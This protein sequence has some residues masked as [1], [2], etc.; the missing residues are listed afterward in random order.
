MENKL[1][2]NI[3]AFRK[4]RM[5]TQE[6]LAEVLGVTVGAVYKWE[7]RLSQPELGTIM[8][9][10]DFFDT[11]VDVLLG[12]EMKD[13]RLQTTTERLKKYRSDKDAAGLAD[14]EKALKK[15]PNS[16][17]I[18]YYSAALYGAFGMERGEKRLLRRALELFEKSRHLIS[19]NA[20]PR[21]SESTLCGSIAEVLLNL[22]ETKRAVDMLK[23]NNADGMYSDRIGLT[24]ADAF[25]CPE[26]ALT[27]LSES[28]VENTVKIIRT[29]FGYVTV[30][31]Q[32]ADFDSAADVL[33]FGIML[34][35][36]L[37]R[38]EK[39]NYMDRP[40]CVLFACL[41]YS[42]L[43]KGD[44]AG[45]ERVL[46]RAKAIAERFDA[47]PNYGV[48]AVRFVSGGEQASAYDDI[49][50]TAADGVRNTVY[51]LD[52]V[53]LIKIWERVNNDEEQSN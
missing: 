5:L 4:Q 42:R 15:Y 28:L 1:A 36:G 27:Y 10:A 19:Q 41:A 46:V 34:S 12:Y 8:E 30:F 52:N 21:I 49:G 45:A 43:M 3:R 11:S 2:E 9:L 13:N 51:S 37:R 17:E 29:V 44:A 53:E 50:A 7:A 32:K 47:E 24:L 33:N 39:T 22:G 6:Q 16:F 38:G 23:A 18:V 20:D 48:E 26:E 31:F 25:D 14:A 35:E 40:M